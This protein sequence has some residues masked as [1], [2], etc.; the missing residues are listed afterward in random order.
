MQNELG[1]LRLD[2]PTPM[3]GYDHEL[4]DPYQLN[5]IPEDRQEP[6]NQLG[7]T[8]FRDAFEDPCQNYFR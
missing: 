7:L 6:D 4:D 3:E 8:E 5:E 1:M 2:T